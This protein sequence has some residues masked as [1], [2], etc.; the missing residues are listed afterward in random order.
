MLRRFR[1]R[2]LFP[3]HCLQF[4]GVDTGHLQLEEHLGA[5][6]R[7]LV[8]D[9]VLLLLVVRGHGLTTGIEAGINL[10]LTWVEDWLS[11]LA[12]PLG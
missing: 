7:Q 12:L 2:C 9:G 3:G 6:L 11:N 1:D 5:N 10:T 8:L 4:L